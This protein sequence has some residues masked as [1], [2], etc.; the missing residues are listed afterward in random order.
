MF[1]FFKPS[2]QS[3]RQLVH[4]CRDG[5]LER[6]RYIVTTLKTAVDWPGN[7]IEGSALWNAAWNNHL[8]VV[9]FL[10][11]AGAS[12]DLVSWRG[13]SALVGAASRGN[14]AVVTYL[15]SKGAETRKG[16]CYGDSAL[17]A[18]ASG[19]YMSVVLY[20]KP[21]SEI[22]KT[23][24]DGKT[25]LILASEK[26]QLQVVEFLCVEGAN[27]DAA[28]L[29]GRTALFMAAVK[30]H[31]AIIQCLVKHGADTEKVDNYGD[32]PLRGAAR[33]VINDIPPQHMLH[34]HVLQITHFPSHFNSS[35][36]CL[37][38][39]LLSGSFGWCA[40]AGRAGIGHRSA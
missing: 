10:V 6:V 4:A 2:E 19:G 32:S 9:E 8:P 20:L 1:S 33:Q 40:L 5:N 27:K 13:E 3:R 34:Q 25:A 12:V 37:M 23:N 18:A 17:I 28:G 24:N 22:D 14:I 26:N 15:V 39:M 21:L 36:S 35:S 30:G 16:N 7:E 31:M 38:I 29:D 11:E